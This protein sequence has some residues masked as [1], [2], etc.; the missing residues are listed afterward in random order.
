MASIALEISRWRN[1]LVDRLPSELSR[2]LR[3]GSRSELVNKADVRIMVYGNQVVD[4]GKGTKRIIAAEGS[5]PSAGE[6][7]DAC[8]HLAGDSPDTSLLLLLSPDEFV[9]T[10]VSMPGMNRDNLESALRLQGDSLLPGYEGSLALAINPMAHDAG[11]VDVALW[12]G[13]N[14]LDE[15]FTAFEAKGILLAAVM[16]RVLY[17]AGDQDSIALDQDEDSSTLVVLRDGALRQWSHISNLDLEQEELA[18][19]WRQ[20]LADTAIPQDITEL[21]SAAVYLEQL[22]K[23]QGNPEYCFF[24]QGA[25]T[26]RKKLETGNRLLLA[27]AAAG[28]VLI[29]A[30]IP[31]LLQTFEY[32][33]LQSE[34]EDQREFSAGARA[35]QAVVVRFE[36]EWGPV[37]DFPDQSIVDT[38]YALQEALSPNTL[39]S[40]EISEGVVQI[41]GEATDPQSILQRL[42]Q[43]PMFTE[44]TFSRATNNSRYYIELR[45]STVNFDAYT[46]RYFAD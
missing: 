29:L 14:R 35:D 37:I 2:V 4:L 31:F 32:T 15:L 7:A 10:S 34:L 13:Q 43:D 38:M 44:V 11:H 16:P 46:V 20:T 45:L 22:D 19:E 25:L 40:L 18:T 42:D 33:N 12:I 41:Q 36:N 1:A 27:G 39:Q 9:A 24:P 21:N 6:L 26:A 28:V 8:R 3:G 23:N 5:P 30:S 17:V